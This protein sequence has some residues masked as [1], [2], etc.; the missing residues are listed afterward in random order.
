MSNYMTRQ[1]L[2]GADHCQWGGLTDRNIYNIHR[3]GHL[4]SR[5]RTMLLQ[6]KW[7][8]TEGKLGNI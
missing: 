1:L 4:A 8:H 6:E 2:M 3:D 5:Y 7:P